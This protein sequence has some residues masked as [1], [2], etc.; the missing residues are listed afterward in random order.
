[1]NTGIYL[2]IV[3]A[4]VTLFVLY[5]LYV[6]VCDFMVRRWWRGR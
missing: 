3:G 6:W 2:A 5:L 1:M 4:G